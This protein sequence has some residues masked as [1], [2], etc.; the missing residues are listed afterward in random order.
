M[1]Y[2]EIEVKFIVDDVAVLRQ[3]IAG[4]EAH[5]HHPRTYEDNWCFDTPDQRFQQEDRLLRLRRDH[6]ILLTYKEPPQTAETEFKVRQEYE[7]EVNDFEQARALVEK[8]G[9]APSLRYEKYRETFRYDEAEIL[10]DETP[11]GA[12]VEIEGPREAIDAIAQQLGLDDAN[13]IT[14]SYGDIF[15]AVRTAYDLPFSDMTFD[16]FRGLAIDLR[17]CQLT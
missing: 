10:L 9:F 15:E 12:F 3:R 8:L 6:R 4:L 2:E 5:L 1:S 13:R 17:T 16:N 7:I 11:L 14:A